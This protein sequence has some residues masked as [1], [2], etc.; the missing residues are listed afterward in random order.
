MF[1]E[2][3]TTGGVVAAAGDTYHDVALDMKDMIVNASGSPWAEVTGSSPTPVW[4]QPYATTAVAA[5]SS[6]TT[7]GFGQH[8]TMYLTTDEGHRTKTV[9]VAGSAGTLIIDIDGTDYSQAFNT[10]AAQTATD[11]LSTHTATLAALGSPVVATAGAGSAEI[12]LYKAAA[13]PV[14]TDDSTGGMSFTW[15]ANCIMIRIVIGYHGVNMTMIDTHQANPATTAEWGMCTRISSTWNPTVSSSSYYGA[16]DCPCFLFKFDGSE[17]SCPDD[18]NFRYF[19]WMWDDCLVILTNSASLSTSYS[20]S[21]GCWLFYPADAS[22]SIPGIARA[23]F[24]HIWGMPGKYSYANGIAKTWFDNRVL[25]PAFSDQSRAADW[26]SD[27]SG[28]ELPS[29]D[30]GPELG[31]MPNGPGIN[32]KIFVQRIMFHASFNPTENTVYSFY[33]GPFNSGPRLISSG[34]AYT[35]GSANGAFRKITI[36]GVDYVQGKLQ[37]GSYTNHECMFLLPLSD[38]TI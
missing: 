18:G 32:G 35:G 21:G 14:L 1:Y 2:N 31:F 15:S 36:G 28:I 20:C 34:D 13:E 7:N 3:Y 37:S 33:S 11:W 17:T 30:Y 6:A 23:D 16:D 12:V 24:P 29:L 19:L 27:T 8:A 10:S 4:L 22:H 5:T 9:T 38:L 25:L 26:R